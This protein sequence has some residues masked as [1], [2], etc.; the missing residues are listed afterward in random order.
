LDGAAVHVSM[1][2][3]DAGSEQTRTLN[4]TPAKTINADL[5]ALYD[6]TVAKPL[7]ENMNIAFMGDTKVGPF[8]IDDETAHKMLAAKGNP[9]G[10]PNSDVVCQWVNGL[11]ITRRPR[12]MWIIDF[13][14]DVPEEKAAQYEMPFEYIRKHVK[15][16]RDH[17]RRKNYREK[18]WL[19]GE[20]RPGMRMALSPLKS[21]IATVRVA[22]HRLFAWLDSGILADCSLFVFARDDDYFFGVLHSRV[23]ELWALRMGTA[24]TDR[25]RY[26]PTT[27]FE[28]FPLPWAPGKEPKSDPRVKAIAKAAQELVALR[29][30]WLNPPGMSESELQKRTLTNLYNERPAWLEIAHRK[31]DEAVLDAYGWPHDLSDD[32]ILARL[33]ELNL[34][35]AAQPENT[36]K[37]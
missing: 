36:G 13:G 19:H 16:L 37:K 3:F 21:Y 22:K 31:L 12:N 23:H 10:R 30:N 8:D 5:T 17:I 4:G 15:P 1:V 7:A 24:L 28:T 2:G 35:R 20:S 25:P 33:L 26:T 27:T 32:D 9:N 11:D 34:A 6:L 14:V 18:W 29:D